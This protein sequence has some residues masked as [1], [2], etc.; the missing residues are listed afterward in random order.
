M[1]A[2]C[3]NYEKAYAEF[4]YNSPLMKKYNEDNRDLYELLSKHSGHT[5]TNPK[6]V[7]YLMD[8]LFIEVNVINLKLKVAFFTFFTKNGPEI[9][10][11]IFF[12]ETEI[13]QLY[14]SRVDK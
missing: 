5:I 13:V 6:E 2:S 1:N 4:K 9:E 11:R 8:D 14:T 10:I 3:P 12:I 7:D